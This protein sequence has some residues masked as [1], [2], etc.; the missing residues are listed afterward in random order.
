MCQL[1]EGMDGLRRG[2]SIN[3]ADGFQLTPRGCTHTHA[4]RLAR[5]RVR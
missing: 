3:V 5:G 2:G 1:G 4:C